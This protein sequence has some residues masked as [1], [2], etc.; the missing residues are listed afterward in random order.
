[1]CPEQYRQPAIRKAQA[2]RRHDCLHLVTRYDATTL[3][4]ILSARRIHIAAKAL[5]C[6]FPQALSLDFLKAGTLQ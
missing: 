2:R 3:S 5:D 6:I 1:M 4:P